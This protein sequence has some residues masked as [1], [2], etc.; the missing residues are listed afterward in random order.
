MKEHRLCFDNGMDTLGGLRD[1]TA[2]GLEWAWDYAHWGFEKAVRGATGAVAETFYHAN[3]L[4]L[5]DLPVGVVKGVGD[6]IHEHFTKTDFEQL[7]SHDRMETIKQLSDQSNWITAFEDSDVRNNVNATP[8]SAS[9]ITPKEYLLSLPIAD[10]EKIFRDFVNHLIPNEVQQKDP[11]NKINNDRNALLALLNRVVGISN[12][13]T[14]D[15]LAKEAVRTH[16]FG[17]SGNASHPRKMLAE[18]MADGLAAQ[19]AH[20]GG[21]TSPSY[22]LLRND[23]PASRLKGALQLGAITPEE[24]QMFADRFKEKEA[25]TTQVTQDVARKIDQMT[26]ATK[27]EMREKSKTMM[28]QWRGLNP[29]LKLGL[30]GAAIAAIAHWRPARWI[31]GVIG[32]V[33]AYRYFIMRDQKPFTSMTGWVTGGVDAL[34]TGFWNATGTEFGKKM[35]MVDA[36]LIEQS[37]LMVDFLEQDD[38]EGLEQEATGLT[39]L[40]DQPI[41]LLASQFNTSKQDIRDWKLDLT[42]GSALDQGLVKAMQD[43]GWKVNHQSFFQHPHNQQEVSE[44]LAHVFYLYARQDRRNFPDVK[45]VEEARRKLPEE[46]GYIQL[47]TIPGGHKAYEAYMRLAKEG[48]AMSRKNSQSLQSVVQLAMGLEPEQALVIN[49]PSISPDPAGGSGGEIKMSESPESD[50][51]GSGEVERS[52]NPTGGAEGVSMASSPDSAGSGVTGMVLQPHANSGAGI[53][54]VTEGTPNA[55]GG[56]VGDTQSSPPP[57]GH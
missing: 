38:R 41:G 43:R 53:G 31:A 3:R 2:R 30:I 9:I 52:P 49:A 16:Y 18:D 32:G 46:A 25:E 20:G 45:L 48:V 26:G 39:L 10:R 37:R 21:V 57:A 44:A 28:D 51:A 14:Y 29:F 24:F 6:V 40:S 47:R 11:F 34:N 36:S 5:R 33:A 17:Q 1:S 22:D 27:L 23:L 55:S 50:G 7:N 4:A 15:D 13:T 8:I 12:D 54:A 56:S 35:N 42:P 19:R